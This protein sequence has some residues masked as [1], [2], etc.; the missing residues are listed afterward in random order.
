MW[1]LHFSRKINR[2]TNPNPNP[3]PYPNAPTGNPKQL[4]F[5]DKWLREG[6]PWWS[7]VKNSPAMQRTWVRSPV[8]ENPAWCWVI[9]SVNPTRSRDPA[10]QQEKSPQ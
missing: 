6:L 4:S 8:R 3:N 7:V 10:W 9:K 5:A 1:D 2:T